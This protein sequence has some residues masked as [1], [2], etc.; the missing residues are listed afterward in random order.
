MSHQSASDSEQHMPPMKVNTWPFKL[1]TILMFVFF[2]AAITLDFFG[3]KLGFN[4]SSLVSYNEVTVH[5]DGSKSTTTRESLIR[6]DVQEKLFGAIK[7]R[8]DALHES[9][10]LLYDFAKITLGAL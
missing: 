4:P 3:S 2:G 5:P 10:K 8:T 7:N 9:A 6:S 1:L